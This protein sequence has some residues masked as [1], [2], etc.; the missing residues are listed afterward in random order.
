MEKSIC[1][2]FL[3]VLMFAGTVFAESFVIRPSGF[4]VPK[5]EMSASVPGVPIVEFDT[6][7]S[8]GGFLGIAKYSPKKYLSFGVEGGFENL[9]IGS[10]APG[11][12][13]ASAKVFTLMAKGCGH[14]QNKSAF[15]P[16]GCG[17]VGMLVIDP[18]LQVTS[19]PAISLNKTATSGFSM[20]AG[21]S[22]AFNDLAVRAGVRVIKTFDD[23]VFSVAGGGFGVPVSID[24]YGLFF[25]LEFN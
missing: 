6:D 5:Q 4:W 13:E 20:E 16:F 1:L 8:F 21:S 17:G 15:T 24:H 12:K 14:L 23:P 10:P 2:S 11:I 7:H 3:L 25:G 22:Y 9:E 18:D 19:G